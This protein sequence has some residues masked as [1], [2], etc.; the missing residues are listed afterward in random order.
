[1]YQMYN[2]MYF[3][4][5]ICVYSVQTLSG[6]IG[7]VLPFLVIYFLMAR[8]GR[9]GGIVRSHL[10]LSYH[11]VSCIVAYLNKAFVGCID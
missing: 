2:A 5:F 10:L 8:A 3:V 9:M 1:M 6:W 11:A 4:M 7:F